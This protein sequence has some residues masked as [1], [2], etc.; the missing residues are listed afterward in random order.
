MNS[1]S[2]VSSCAVRVAPPRTRIVAGSRL[3]AISGG[4]IGLVI[5]GLST[6]RPRRSGQQKTPVP[7]GPGLLRTPDLLAL[8]LRGRKPVG[9]NLPRS[10][11]GNPGLPQCQ[12]ASVREFK[13]P[14]PGL[15]DLAVKCSK[16]TAGRRQ[17]A[18]E[19]LA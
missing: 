10:A 3:S 9:S 16:K 4:S 19:I 13:A 6:S 14:G 5:G 15:A 8:V 17:A 7:R 18:A 12:A 2:Q 11:V 1:A